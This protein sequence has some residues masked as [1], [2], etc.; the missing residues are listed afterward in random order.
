[1]VGRQGYGETLQTVVTCCMMNLGMWSNLRG[2]SGGR[3]VITEECVHCC[4]AVQKIHFGNELTG[5][6]DS[7]T[8]NEK[9]N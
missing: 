9:V 5:H 4:L 3:L 7:Q 2:R 1:M 6:L 8:E